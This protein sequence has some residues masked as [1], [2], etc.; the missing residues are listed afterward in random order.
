[1]TVIS[2]NLAFCQL[3]CHSTVTCHC[4]KSVLRII[5]HPL[6]KIFHKSFVCHSVSV[7]TLTRVSRM[8]LK[9]SPCSCSTVCR[10]WYDCCTA[11]LLLEK[12]GGCSSWAPLCL[13]PWL[14]SHTWTRDRAY[15]AH[16][17]HTASYH[18]HHHHH[19]HHLVLH[20]AALHHGL[21]AR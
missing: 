14:A 8:L 20:Q 21:L 2:V 5:C 19:H 3:S 10:V 12:G 17:W 1:M 4:N 18:H 6:H 9:V 11:W 7:S 13:S 15:S 16:C